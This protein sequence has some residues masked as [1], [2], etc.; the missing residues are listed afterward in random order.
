MTEKE[1]RLIC[2]IAI[3]E[4]RCKELLEKLADGYTP[5]IT[6]LRTHFYLERQDKLL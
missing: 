1:A 3:K 6:K 2:E 4:G 5:Q